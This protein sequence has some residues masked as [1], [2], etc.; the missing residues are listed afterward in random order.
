MSKY[1]T[2]EGNINFQEELYK[3]LDEDSDNEDELCQI[4]GAPL[5]ENHVVLECN[6]HFNYEPLY[7]EIYRQRFQ[8]NT[9]EP[10][11]LS[12]PD[13]KKFRDSNLDYFIKFK[14]LYVKQVVV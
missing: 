1:Y 3:L 9:Y 13:L 14:I 2:V 10:N 7:K 11:T 12:K 6:H 5:K 8:F 4:T